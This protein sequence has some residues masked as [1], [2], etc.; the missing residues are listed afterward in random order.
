MPD[1]SLRKVLGRFLTLLFASEKLFPAL[2]LNVRAVSLKLTAYVIVK[3][4][5]KFPSL[6][7]AMYWI[8]GVGQKAVEEASRL[9]ERMSKR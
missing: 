1:L 3:K 2:H 6:N 5:T 7:L 4:S 8:K 9:Q